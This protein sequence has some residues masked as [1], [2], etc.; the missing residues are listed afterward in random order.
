MAVERLV[1]RAV[2]VIR[3]LAGAAAAG[4]L[5]LGWATHGPISTQANRGGRGRYRRRC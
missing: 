1:S 4:L 3:I 2:E 5:L